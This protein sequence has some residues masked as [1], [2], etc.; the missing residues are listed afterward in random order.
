M[1]ALRNLIF[2]SALLGSVF[3]HSVAIRRYRQKLW[4][5]P[6][7]ITTYLAVSLLLC[8]RFYLNP[9]DFMTLITLAVLGGGTF[10]CLWTACW[11][12]RPARPIAICLGSLGVFGV[13]FSLD[14]FVIEPHWLEVERLT[15]NSPKVTKPFLVAVL[16]DIQTDSVGAYEERVLNTALQAKPDLILMPGDFLQSHDPRQKAL[17]NELMRRANLQTPLGAYA[18][19]GNVDAPDWPDL[20]KGSAVR[21]MPVRERLEREAFVLTGLPLEESFDPKLEVGPE[22]KFH[23]AMGH[24]PDFALGN[25]QADLLVAGHTH[26]GQIQVPFF[27]PPLTL[28]RVPREWAAGGLTSLP[29]GASLLVSRGIGMER[30]GAPP[31]RFRCRPHLVLLELQ[32]EQKH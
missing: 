7:A 3:V 6:L 10:L 15:L 22:Q 23:I 27:G 26:G 14:A 4:I 2:L 24:C 18:V 8:F 9:F 5:Y 20:F 30:D 31:I 32:P 1:E 12:W 25:V 19:G 16:A 21:C 17:F 13:V 28:S 11:A 29:S